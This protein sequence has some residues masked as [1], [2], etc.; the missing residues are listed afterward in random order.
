[1][2]S[3]VLSDNVAR[4]PLWGANSLVNFPDRDVA[5]KTGSTNNFYDAWMMGYTPNLAVGV[6]VGNNIPASMNGL[7]GL[8]VTPM[9]REFMDFALEK[10]DKEYFTQPNIDLVGKKPIIRGEYID[11]SIVGQ[12]LLDSGDDTLSMA[13]IT[14]NI[15]TILHFVDKNDP[16]GNYPSNPAQDP[17]YYNW[18]YA[19]QEWKKATYGALLNQPIEEVITEE[20]ESNN[21]RNNRR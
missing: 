11:A 16:N 14:N 7:S 12:Q 1:M 2:I 18:E 15:H 8:I 19:V 17:Q 9:W 3:D 5:S 13:N 20:D 21:N 4:T 6:W 10:R